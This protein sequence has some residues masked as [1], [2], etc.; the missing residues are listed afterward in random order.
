VTFALAVAGAVA[1]VVLQV[2]LSYVWRSATTFVDPFLVLAVVSGLTFERVPAIFAGLVAGL[3]RD[4]YWSDWFGLNGFTKVVVAYAA[5]AL[6]TRLDLSQSVPRILALATA[7]VVDR[8]LQLG[9]K[10]AMGR[11]A[12]P[13]PAS[14]WLLGIAA[15]VALGLL[16]FAV[17]DRLRGRP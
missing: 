11:A 16:A 8:T 13:A 2:I 14:E 1:A 5:S 6:G 15:T 17:L 4:S 9:L 3:T 7:S 12:A 10:A